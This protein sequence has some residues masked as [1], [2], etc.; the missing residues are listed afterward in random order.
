MREEGEGL[1]GERRIGKW[2]EKKSKGGGQGE[3]ARRAKRRGGPLLLRGLVLLSWH[4]RPS[5]RPVPLCVPHHRRKERKKKTKHTPT[6]NQN[7]MDTSLALVFLS[8]A[9]LSSTHGA[10]EEEA[11][12]LPAGRPSIHPA[13]PGCPSAF[14]CLNRLIDPVVVHASIS[15]EININ[16]QYMEP[17]TRGP[18]RPIFFKH[19]TRERPTLFGKRAS[20]FPSGLAVSPC[21]WCDACILLP[22][23]KHKQS[24]SPFSYSTTQ[25]IERRDKRCRSDAR[26][27]PSCS[28][29]VRVC[30]HA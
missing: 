2:E 14:R 1:G 7:H 29:W 21:L 16:M 22:P 3:G 10:R 12:R 15:I 5:P 11:E 19:T 6:Q 27:P 24:H 17:Q 23:L 20:E 9:L 4:V 30:M 25:I 26:R 28:S 13:L 18:F 8:F